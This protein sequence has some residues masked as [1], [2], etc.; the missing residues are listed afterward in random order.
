MTE[1]IPHYTHIIFQTV[2]RLEICVIS[3]VCKILQ[4]LQFHS[5]I[6]ATCHLVRLP[7]TTLPI[8]GSIVKGVNLKWMVLIVNP[9]INVLGPLFLFSLAII[10]NI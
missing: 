8:F 2:Q 4:I 7:V 6:L 5:D 1:F 9:K 3:I 10:W